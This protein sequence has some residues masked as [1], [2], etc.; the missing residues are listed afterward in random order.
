MSPGVFGWSDESTPSTTIPL[1]VKNKDSQ[2]RSINVE[3][4]VIQAEGPVV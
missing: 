1:K 2:A 4:T 3:L